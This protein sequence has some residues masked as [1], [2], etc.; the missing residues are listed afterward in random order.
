MNRERIERKVAAWDEGAWVRQAAVAY[1]A[2]QSSRTEV[3]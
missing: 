2:K 1:A 3:A